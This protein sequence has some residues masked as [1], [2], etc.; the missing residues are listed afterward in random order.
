L[1]CRKIWIWAYAHLSLWPMLQY[2][3]KRIQK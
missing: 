2:C 3:I 1:S